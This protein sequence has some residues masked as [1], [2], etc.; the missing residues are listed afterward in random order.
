MSMSRESFFQSL[1]KKSYDELLSE[2]RAFV[3]K[4][5]SEPPLKEDVNSTA[6][7][8][9]GEW[10]SLD[11]FAYSDWGNTTETVLAADQLLASWHDIMRRLCV[12]AIKNAEAE[13]TIE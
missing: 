4:M 13:F 1:L 9:P 11:D 3:A 6:G 12:V 8:L 5:E 7:V 2:A 10:Q